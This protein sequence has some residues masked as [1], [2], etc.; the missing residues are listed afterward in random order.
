M[1]PRPTL[2]SRT[3]RGVSSSTW[4][5]TSGREHTGTRDFLLH[6]Q[7]VGVVS[8]TWAS[9]AQTLGLPPTLGRSRARLVYPSLLTESF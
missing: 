9:L 2:P 4:P 3:Q 1:A 6:F 5:V 8:Q 7:R